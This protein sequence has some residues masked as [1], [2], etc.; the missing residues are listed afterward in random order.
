[1]AELFYPSQL[2]DAVAK[3]LEAVGPTGLGQPDQARHEDARRYVW[4]PS[5][6]TFTGPRRPDTVDGVD[7]AFSI[8]CWGHNFDDAFWMV[9]ALLA[10]LQKALG[11]RNYT[12]S[13]MRPTT[14]LVTARGFVWTVDLH[15][16]LHFPATDL[17]RPPPAPEQRSSVGADAVPP[18]EP[19]YQPT[20]ETEATITAV[21]QASPA[22][23]TPGDGVLESEET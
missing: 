4:L 7:L 17:Q 18:A 11:G 22:T 12:A 20:G 21:A 2:V 3:E 16:R 10:A 13:R 19:T 14:E 23:S 15:L 8:E 5:D 6:S 9:G 1:M